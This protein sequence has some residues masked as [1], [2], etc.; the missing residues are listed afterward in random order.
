MALLPHPHPPPLNGIGRFHHHHPTVMWVGECGRGFPPLRKALRSQNPLLSNHELFFS[1]IFARYLVFAAAR[2]PP[3]PLQC[4]FDRPTIYGW[5]LLCA[6]LRVVLASRESVGKNLCCAQSE[7]V[8]AKRFFSSS[9]RNVSMAVTFLPVRP[10]CDTGPSRPGEQIITWSRIRP[11]F[12]TREE[13]TW[14]Q[15]Y[16][17]SYWRWVQRDLIDSTGSAG[18]AILILTWVHSDPFVLGSLATPDID[19]IQYCVLPRSGVPPILL[20]C[21]FPISLFILYFCYFLLY[22]SRVVIFVYSFTISL[23]GSKEK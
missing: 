17:L 23:S 11:R 22:F 3:P 7:V 8:I 5:L 18:L 6:C 15:Q 19:S 13:L 2:Q 1:P 16:S 21:F 10:Y 9:D 4:L 20:H 12:I 14:V